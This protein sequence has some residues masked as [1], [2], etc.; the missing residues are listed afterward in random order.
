[1]KSENVV[2]SAILVVTV[3]LSWVALVA[4]TGDSGSELVV[5]TVADQAYVATR[6]DAVLDQVA[7]ENAQ[8]D[9]A[10]AVPPV[11]R[12][13]TETEEEIFTRVNDLFRQVTDG[14]IEEQTLPVPSANIDPDLATTTTTTTAATTTS[15]TD[16]GDG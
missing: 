15:N 12:R 11:L 3:A 8:N 10:E 4:G 9:A 16:G 14:V 2:K 1:M 7:Y 6:D 5:N 13:D